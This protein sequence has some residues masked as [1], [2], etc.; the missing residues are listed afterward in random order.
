MNIYV[1][2]PEGVTEPDCIPSFTPTT[3]VAIASNSYLAGQL[4]RAYLNGDKA[5]CLC[6]FQCCLVTALLDD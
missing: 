5:P 1:I 3:I 6:R 2:T 4:A